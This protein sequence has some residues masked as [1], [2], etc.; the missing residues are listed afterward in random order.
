MTHLNFD[1]LFEKFKDAYQQIGL[2]GLLM[3]VFYQKEH[4]LVYIT[5]DLN[6]ELAVPVR[7][8]LEVQHIE[9]QHLPA[10]GEFCKPY[11]L[12]NKSPIEEFEE[13]RRNGG[14]GLIAKVDGRILGFQWWAD[15]TIGT[16]FEDT[17]LRCM[18]SDA[19]LNDDE[20]YA[21]D[22]FLDPRYR[23]C[24]YGGEFQRRLFVELKKQGYNRV[25]AWV[26]EENTRARRS[27]RRMG[28]E[29]RQK[30]V[31]RRFFLFFM[32]RGKKLFFDRRGYRH[33]YNLADDVDTE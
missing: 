23:G 32:F 25:I 1:R 33:L 28:W 26:L 7:S 4:V 30:L 8:E 12:Y 10:L 19:K 6:E 20:V 29:E 9:D 22:I 14:N 24:G 27:Y 2:K 15:N 13:Y 11:N 21:F 16:D 5:R 3:N 17:N 31:I 18:R